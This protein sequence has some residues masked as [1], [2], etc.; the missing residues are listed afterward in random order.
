MND[1]GLN[2]EYLSG[3]RD[4]V[5]EELPELADQTEIMFDIQM[6]HPRALR[7]LEKYVNSKQPHLSK[8]VKKPSSKPLNRHNHTKESNNKH[9]NNQTYN[10]PSV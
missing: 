10:Q 9:S 5:C 4:I 2:D 3:I 6:L 1:I 7:R 8:L